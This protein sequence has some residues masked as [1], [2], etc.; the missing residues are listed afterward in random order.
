MKIDIR[1]HAYVLLFHNLA[2]GTTAKE[3]SQWAWQETGLSLEPEYI[4]IRPAG[5]LRCTAIAPVSRHALAD[6]FQ[7]M[8]ADKKFKGQSVA[9]RS[10]GY[11]QNG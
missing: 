8:L 11:K 6:F 4:D 2:T 3:V 9:V 10:A 1:L 7:R 5:D